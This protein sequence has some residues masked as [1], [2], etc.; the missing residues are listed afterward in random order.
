MRRL[1]NLITGII[2]KLNI[3]SHLALQNVALRQQLIVLKR[4]CNKPAIRNRDRLFWMLFSR[5]WSNWKDSLI[6]VKP[7]TV[8][9]WHRKGF[10]LFWKYKSRSRSPGR[11]SVSKEIRNLVCRMA[12]ANLLW[13]APRIHGELIAIMRLEYCSNG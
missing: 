9:A 6:I 8:L 10:K 5:L 4:G 12:N 13:G 7:Q 11:P 2:F 1:W 3:T